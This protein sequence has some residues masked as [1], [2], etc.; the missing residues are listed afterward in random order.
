MDKKEDLAKSLIK[1][2]VDN[3]TS[4][5]ND[6]LYSMMHHSHPTLPERLRAMEQFDQDRKA[7]SGVKSE[8]K[9]DL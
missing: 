7:K 3:L 6:K 5:H 4:P 2:H 8:G 9:K 1:L